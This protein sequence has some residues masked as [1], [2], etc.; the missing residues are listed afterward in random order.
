MNKFSKVIIIFIVLSSLVI[1]FINFERSSAQKD[2]TKILELEISSEENR[3]AFKKKIPSEIFME[4]MP[5]SNFKDQF[6]NLDIDLK[7]KV[8][9]RII[10]TPQLTNDINS[11]RLTSDGEIYYRCFEH[12]HHHYHKVEKSPISNIKKASISEYNSIVSTNNPPQLSSREQASIYIYL[13]FNGEIV[14]NTAWNND[15]DYNYQ[16]SW[17]CRPFDKDGDEAT[18]SINEQEQIEYIWRE[19]VEDFSGFDVNI[20]TVEPNQNTYFLHALITPVIDKNG[21]SCPHDG[22]GGIGFLGNP[23]YNISQYYSPVWINSVFS[24]DNIGS[25]ISHEI[26]HNLSLNHDGSAQSGEYYSGHQGNNIPSWGPIMGNPYNRNITQWSKGEYYGASNTSEDD[27]AIIGSKLGVLA[28]D[29][30]DTFNAAQLLDDNEIIGLIG[31][32]S[33][34]D[35]FKFILSFDQNVTFDLSPYTNSTYGLSRWSWGGNADL[36]LEIY[37]SEFSLL[38]SE[39]SSSDLSA[40]YQGFLTAGIYYIKIKSTGAGSPFNSSPSGYTSYGSRGNYTM[41]FTDFINDDTDGDGML[42]SWEQQYFNTISPTSDT[43]SDGDGFTNLDEFIAGTNPTNANSLFNINV[44]GSNNNFIIQWNAVDNK[45]YNVFINNDLRFGEFSNI[46]GDLPYPVNS[47][48][49]SVQRTENR[50]Y[51]KLEVR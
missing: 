31:N 25:I 24:E 46:S 14:E 34:E 28:D 47:Y 29:Y 11:L 48:T 4:S 37:N 5:E 45:I 26:G 40:S 43:D 44:L 9:Q 41:M 27:L 8:F 21:V 15:A 30:A 38:G 2:Q 7:E 50:Q 13:D 3:Q 36:A 51:Y 23:N 16:S 22:A 49:D 17:D 35:C 10:L 32:S 12:D 33:D 42:D 6:K 18:F 19:V 1:M 39:N 20:T